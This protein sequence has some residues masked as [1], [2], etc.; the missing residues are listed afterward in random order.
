MTKLAFKV[1]LI[2]CFFNNAVVAQQILQST[3]VKGYA[4]DIKQL[5]NKSYFVPC[6]FV[7]EN[8]FKVGEYVLDK[9]LTERSFVDEKRDAW[10]YQNGIVLGEQHTF[11]VTSY[12]LRPLEGPD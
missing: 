1:L 6:T 4:F 12:L 10:I 2:S 3:V 5:R 9:K 7:A 8:S 11:Y